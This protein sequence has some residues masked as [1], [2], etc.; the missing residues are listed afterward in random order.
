MKKCYAVDD[1]LPVGSV[2]HW[3][4]CTNCKPL[5]ERLV[6][7]IQLVAIFSISLPVHHSQLFE[8]SPLL[9]RT[10]ALIKPTKQTPINRLRNRAFKNLALS[11]THPHF[12][13]PNRII[14]VLKQMTVQFLECWRTVGLSIRGRLT[15]QLHNK[16]PPHL[17]NELQNTNFLAHIR[18]LYNEEPCYTT[19]IFITTITKA[20][21]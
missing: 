8:Q 17:T 20:I 15:C 5:R 14:T 3:T 12:T 21:K 1:A 4:P 7:C 16:L 19:H 10:P 13:S 6:Y 11:C 18:Y 2:F 9:K